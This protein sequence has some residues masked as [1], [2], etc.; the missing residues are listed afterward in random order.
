MY[1]IDLAKDYFVFIEQREGQIM[2]VSL[3]LIGEATRLVKR[4]DGYKV[5]GILLGHNIKGLAKEA[6]AY[7]CDKVIVVDHETLDVFVPEPYTKAMASIVNEYKP[8]GL[9]IGATTIGRDLG[10][11]VAARVETGLTADATVI[12]VDPEDEGTKL[13]WITRPAFGGNLFGTIICPDHRPQMATIRPGV[14]V[15]NEKN[16]SLKGEIIEHDAKLTKED[17]NV[18][19]IEI[20]KKVAEGIDITKAEIVISG[21]RGIGGPEGFKVLE[22]VAHNIGGNVAG[23]RAAVDA[24]WIEKAQQVGQTGK[25]IRPLVYIACGISGAVQHTAGMDKADFIIAINKDKYAPI[26]DVAHLGIVGDAFEVLPE[27]E[28]QLLK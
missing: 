10:P 24:G 16:D 6:I 18:E 3:E 22:K 27:L 2:D 9:F 14:L 5:V 12:E 26:F 15:K 8:D 17:V 1:D 13:L 4:T 19:I 25:T 20:V 7:G 23:S 28:K 21:G 11:R